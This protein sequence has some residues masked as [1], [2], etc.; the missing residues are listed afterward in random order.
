[1][2]NSPRIALV[3]EA[4][5]YSGPALART[6]AA[7]GHHLVLG[8]AG[9]DLVA[10]L[11]AGGT[12]VVNVT[13]LGYLREASASQRMVDAALSE[14]GR[15]DAATTAT[16][17][18]VTGRFLDSSLEDFHRAVKGCLEIPYHFLRAVV[19]VMAEQGSGQVLLQTS[20]TGGRT[21]PGAPLYSMARAGANHLV[22]NVAAE[23]AGR[24]VQVNAVGTNFMDF[25]G[26]LVANGVT[27]PETRARVEALVPMG[28]L[29]DLDEFAA[30][31]AA[32]LD[33]TSTFVTGQ[34]V[35]YS[36]GWG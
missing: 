3:G 24:G 22:R 4:A 7:R 14:F 5:S 34:F 18:I 23:V 11:E 16:G 29:G 12:S 30:F 36:G 28:R 26:F 6:L 10:E 21:S 13:G 8:D 20:A 1:M 19:P 32:F 31:C 9:A 2:T 15:I 17:I 33:G 27:S 25:P 35:S